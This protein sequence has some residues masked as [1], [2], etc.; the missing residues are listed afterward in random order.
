MD[1]EELMSRRARSF[2][3]TA[4]AYA[5][6]R[7]DYPADGIRWGLAAATG[8]VT[9]VLDLAAGTGKLTGGLLALGV[10]VTAVEPDVAMLA[11][12]TERFPAARAVAGRAER[13]PL[14]DGAV[15]AVTVGQAFHWFDRD[16][17]LPEIARVLRPGGA[18]AALWNRED[19]S[20]EWVA[21]M[22]RF[23]RSSVTQ[24]WPADYPLFDGAHFE[25]GEK[26]RFPHEHRR[27]ADSLTAT[28][29]TQSHT[30]V[31]SDEERALVLG[32][33]RDYLGSRPETASGEFVMPLVTTVLRGRRR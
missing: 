29:G 28:I 25:A 12:L 13:I 8:E 2:G 4:A 26:A 30:L 33:T 32:R 14:P 22:G 9:R 5:E 23:A 31:V 7:P 6:H 1:A 16:A 27:T 21:A 19:D 17:A 24:G 11:E 10:A 15:D 20:V 18:L 3:P